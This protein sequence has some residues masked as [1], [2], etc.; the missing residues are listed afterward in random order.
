MKSMKALKGNGGKHLDHDPGT[1]NI[2]QSH[3]NHL[4]FTDVNASGAHTTLSGAC[5]KV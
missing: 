3:I 5:V 1:K 4:T 2:I